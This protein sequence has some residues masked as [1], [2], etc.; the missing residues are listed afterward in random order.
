MSAPTRSVTVRLKE[1]T[2]CTSSISLTLVRYRAA[3]NLTGEWPA[4]TKQGSTSAGSPSAR[5]FFAVVAV[6][7]VAALAALPGIDEVR[8][9]VLE[10]RA[11]LDRGRRRASA[12][13]DARLRA[14]AVVGLRPRDAVAARARARAGR[15]GRE[16]PAARGRRGRPGL[17]RLRADAPRR[18]RPTSPPSATPRC[19]SSRA[20][21]ASAR[22]SFAGGL[23]AVG[24]LPGDAALI[25]TL[26]PAAAIAVVFVLVVLFG[27][28]SPP[29]EPTRGP[30]PAARAG[31]SGASSTTACARRSTLVLPRRPAADLRLGHLLRV[32][33]RQPRLHVP[34]LRRRR[35]RRSA[36][37]SSPTRS[38]TPA[39]CC[40]R[41]AA[42]AAPRAA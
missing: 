7:A 2:C 40:P 39:R 24:M 34:G 21:S 32:R 31:A 25:M 18:A 20:P 19:S 23:T 15:A 42:S 16:R 29:Q 8:D 33:R 4:P 37:S 9:R 30:R 5:L 22:S 17:R 28:S 11:R 10:R 3:A 1:R 13:L 27:R 14:R 36:S 35:A 26:L 41:P 12:A 6:L 38:A